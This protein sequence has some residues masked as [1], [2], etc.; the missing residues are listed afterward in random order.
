MKR[1]V[2]L[3]LLLCL[4]TNVMAGTVG[5]NK[6]ER[7]LDEYQFAM[8]VEWDQ[9]D[10][11]FKEEKTKAFHA[12]MEEIIREEGVSQLEVMSLLQKKVISHEAL[13]AIQLKLALLGNASTPQALAKSLESSTKDMYSQGASWSGEVIIPLAIGLVVVAVIAYKWW[14]E[15]N[16]VCAEW[17]YN[18][19]E[20]VTS[21]WDN[22]DCT[23]HTDEDGFSYETCDTY[24]DA[25]TT[26]TCGPMNTCVRYERIQKN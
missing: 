26:V 13:Q 24:W 19:Y 10:Q 20:C 3:F 9:K 5:M 12:A 4:S 11:K 18:E 6:L 25:E 21:H 2:S 7:A 14:W 15:K 17:R 23:T 22:R 16:H 8:T 1:L